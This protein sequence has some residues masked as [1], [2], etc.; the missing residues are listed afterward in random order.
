MRTDNSFLGDKIA[1]R[2][3]MIPK[4]KT[5]KVIDAYAGRGTIWKNIQ[6]KY[7]GKIEIVKIDKEQKDEGFM[8]IGDNVK[9]LSSLPLHKYDVIDLDAYGVPYRQLKTVFESKFKGMVFVTF[10]QSYQGRLPNEFLEDIGY[11]KKM[12]DKCPSLF[13]KKGQMKLEQWLAIHGIR[14]IIIRKASRKSYLGFQIQ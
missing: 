7:A 1:L 13:S 9:F 14:K 11:T 6:K 4:K 2:F 5:L 3:S 12:I 10:I 8:F